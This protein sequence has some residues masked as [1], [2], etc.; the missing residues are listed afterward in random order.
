MHYSEPHVRAKPAAATGFASHR[1]GWKE[2]A[3]SP[4]LKPAKDVR[5]TKDLRHVGVFWMGGQMAEPA[6]HVAA[7][8][9]VP[10]PN[11]R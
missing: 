6:L 5:T 7:L 2:G 8:V 11:L 3:I 4:L 1:D 10:M 9:T